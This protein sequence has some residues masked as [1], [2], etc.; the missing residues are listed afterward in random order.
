MVFKVVGY[1]QAQVSGAM[2]IIENKQKW[3]VVRTL[4]GCAVCIGMNLLLI[5]RLGTMGAAITSVVTA[6]CTGYLAH[7][8]IPSYRGL[9]SM[10]T[11]SFLIGWKDLAVETTKYI[12]KKCK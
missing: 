8:L 2:I 9:I 3:V 1:A 10:Q 5:P 7:L 12:Q 6:I 11:K 4:I